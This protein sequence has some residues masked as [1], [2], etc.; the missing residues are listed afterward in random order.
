MNSDFAVGFLLGLSIGFLS[1]VIVAI[2]ELRK[3]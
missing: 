3:P 2:I 1:I